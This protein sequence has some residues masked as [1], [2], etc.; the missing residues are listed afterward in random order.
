MKDRGEKGKEGSGGDKS[1]T[2]R[3][4][5]RERY[6]MEK[7]IGREKKMESVH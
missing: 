3:E 1:D 6:A 4:R 2:I 7:K 5:E